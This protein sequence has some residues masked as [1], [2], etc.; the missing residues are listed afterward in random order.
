MQQYA[1]RV[2]SSPAASRSSDVTIGIFSFRYPAQVDIPLWRD[3]T[4][5]CEMERVQVLHE[6]QGPAPGAK[7]RR[8]DTAP[9][10][11][12]GKTETGVEQ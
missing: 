6:R 12:V 9:G 5:L 10:R 3:G 1:R 11:V 7:A 4:L 8:V 2:P